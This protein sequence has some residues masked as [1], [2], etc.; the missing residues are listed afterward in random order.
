MPAGLSAAKELDMESGK[1]VAALLAL[2]V[3]ALRPL[4]ANAQSA[5]YGIGDLPDSSQCVT[6]TPAVTAGSYTINGSF[7]ITAMD[8]SGHV[9]VE[10]PVPQSY[11]QAINDP[12]GVAA[13]IGLN[14]TAMSQACNGVFAAASATQDVP[15]PAQGASGI[16]YAIHSTAALASN[17]MLTITQHGTST[18][19][20][21]WV[22]GGTCNSFSADLLITTTYNVTTG[23]YSISLVSS[24]DDTSTDGVNNYATTY[25]GSG[26]ASGSYVVTQSGQASAIYSEVRDATKV[27]GVIIAVGNS[28]RNPG[29]T[30]SDTGVLWTSTGG[31]VALPAVVAND[32]NTE[33]VSGRAMTRDGRVIAGS[34]HNSATGRDRVAVLV[35]NNGTTNTVLGLLPGG[36]IQS[37]ANAVSEDGSVAYGFSRYDSAGPFQAFRW[38]SVG[39]IVPLGFLS[40]GDVASLPA[41]RGVSSDGSLMVGT[42]SIS[43]PATPFG[44]GNRAFR[45]VAGTGMTALPL[46]SG[47]VGNQALAVTPDGNVALGAGDSTAF[48]NGELVRWTASPALTESLGSPDPALSPN[49]LGG[50]TADGQVA[51]DTFNNATITSGYLRNAHGWFELS[52]VLADAGIGLTGWSLDAVLGVSP[53]G[54]LVFGAG[55]HNG[56]VEGWVAEVPANYLRDY[57]L[58]IAPFVLTAPVA[59]A[60]VRPG[61]LVSVSWTGGDPAGTVNLSLIDNDA[62]TVVQT[63]GDLANIGTYDWTFS[64]SLPYGGPCG[65]GYRFYVEKPDKTQWAYGDVFTVSCADTTP[66]VITPTVT[67]LLG[68]SGWYRSTVSIAWQVNDPES[69]ISSSQGCGSSTV[70]NDTL[71]TT[72]TCTATS[73]GG[74]STASV[75]IKRDTI[76]PLALV[77]SP[78][79]GLTYNRNQ[80]VNAIYFCLDIPSGIAQCIGTVPS[81]SRIDTSSAGTK[82][83]TVNARDQAGNTRT[84]TVQYRV[85]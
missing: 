51:V 37:A 19:C 60:V 16:A 20:V 33:F 53:D 71:G 78:F 59:S 68:D 34:A 72:F 46:L 40:S 5:F 55:Q 82:S 77:L 21:P 66:P 14:A 50:I 85:R 13:S 27:G 41:A 48:P 43:A 74:T 54:T 45:Y 38:T 11:S 3:V 30:A 8:A 24:Y 17:G 4:A 52:T 62:N 56:N 7:T 29:S 81:G 80:R 9:T 6:Y 70:A 67:G 28:A 36:T 64:T 79:N 47:G 39:G 58:V 69:A 18:T 35:T 23:A 73:A 84:A 25:S 15:A 76:A 1:F 12:I 26:M 57:G 10:P 65:R 75:T 2:S 83:F 63:V 49:N 61:Q 42:S 22:P 44:S 32:T 31:L